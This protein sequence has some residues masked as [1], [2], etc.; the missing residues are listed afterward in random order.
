MYV[1]FTASG[2][3]DMLTCLVTHVPL[4]VD[5]LVMAVAAFT[6]GKLVQMENKQDWQVVFEG[7]GYKDQKYYSVV[8][9][10]RKSTSHT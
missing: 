9:L 10:P 6:Q 8:T 4:G 7:S 2:I 3:T 5:R 1:F